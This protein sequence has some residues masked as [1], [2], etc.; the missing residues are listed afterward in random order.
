M[1]S[2]NPQTNMTGFVLI[3]IKGTVTF[4]HDTAKGA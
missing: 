4:W 3:W 1:G 2:Y